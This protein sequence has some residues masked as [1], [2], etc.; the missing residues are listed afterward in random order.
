MSLK[1]FHILFIVLS[2]TLTVWFGRWA[3]SPD[4]SGAN[5]SV[6]RAFGVGSYACAVALL[7]YGV[8]FFKKLTTLSA[9][10]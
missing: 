1:A 5:V 10:R 7:I 8:T 2:V 6:I 9:I 3:T 4:L